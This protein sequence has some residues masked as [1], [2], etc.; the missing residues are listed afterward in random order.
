PA[1]GRTSRLAGMATDA[2]TIT[3]VGPGGRTVEVRL[4]S[5]DKVVWPATD[6][7]AAITKADLAAYLGAVAEP[8]LRG[9]ADRPVTLQRVRG[10][11]EG[12]EFYSKN[13]PKGVPEWSRTT[14]V[15]YPSGRSHPQLVVDDEAT[16]L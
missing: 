13:P 2:T 5:P 12:E 10:G 15:T 16:L 14:M 7:G 8:M 3:A 1:S 4:S 11:I 9:L 6:H